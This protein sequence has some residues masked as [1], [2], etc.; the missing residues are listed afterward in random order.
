MLLHLQQFQVDLTDALQGFLEL[1]VVAQPLLNGRLLFGAKAEL[2]GA[3]A[4]IADC[5]NPDWVAL[6]VFTDGTAGAM[7]NE[8]V[9]QRAADDFGSEWE[10]SGEFGAPAKDGFLIHLSY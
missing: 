9:E 4:R 3:A 10:G 7:A 1:V 8:S 5:Q 2:S 6:S